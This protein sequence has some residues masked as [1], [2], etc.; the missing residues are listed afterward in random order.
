MQ[1]VTKVIQFYLFCYLFFSLRFFGTYLECH[2]W[3]LQFWSQVVYQPFRSFFCEQIHHCGQ[4]RIPL[5]QNLG[6]EWRFDI[7]NNC[8]LVKQLL[9]TCQAISKHSPSA[10][11]ALAECLPS[12]CR[13]LVKCF[14]WACQALVKG[15]PRACWDMMMACQA[16]AN[17]LL[18]TF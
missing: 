3:I 15:L 5:S 11:Q 17:H 14:P 1:Y 16:H 7:G 6:R 12:T 4:F 2:F 8:A 10:C 18:G 13:V 9:S